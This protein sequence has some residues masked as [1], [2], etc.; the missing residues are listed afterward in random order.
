M[1]SPTWRSS[2]VLKLWVTI[3]A[4]VILVFAVLSVL[5]Q[6]FLDGYMWQQQTPQLEQ[7][8]SITSYFV[9]VHDTKAITELAAVHR[10]EILYGSVTSSKHSLVRAKYDE[11]NNAQKL[12]LKQGHSVIERTIDHGVDT[13]RIVRPLPSPIGQQ[14]V[15]VVSQSTHGIVQTLARMRNIISFAMVLGIVLTTVMAFVISNKVSRPLLEMN[16]IAEQM[17]SGN[18][19]GKIRVASNDEVGRLGTTFN[20]LA[21][22]LEHSLETMNMERKQLSS[23]L[24]SLTDGVV[25]SDLEGFITLANPPALRRLS[26]VWLIDSGQPETS[27][28]PQPLEVMLT[29]VVESNST[30]VREFLWQDR[31]VRITMTPLYEQNGQTLRGTVA[32]LRDVTEERRLDRLRKDFIANV[33]HEL[34]TPLSMMQG[35]A[36]ALLDEFGDNPAQ[37]RQLTEIIHDETLRMRRLVNDLLDLAQLES[38]HF[39]L[40][41]FRLD[42][43]ALVR[44]VAR[45]FEALASEQGLYFDTQVHSQPIY[46]NGDEDRLEQVFTNLLDNAIRHTKS[47][48][49]VWIDL[50]ANRNHARV[51]V[52]DTGS[53]IPEEDLPY[54]WERFYKADKARTRTSSGIGLGLAITRHIVN[55]H[56]GDIVVDSQVGVGTTFTVI[57]PVAK[58]Q[59]KDQTRGQGG[60]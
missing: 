8:A 15:I 53:G 23:I 29:A 12:T 2:I 42:L 1:K 38:G 21:S 58:E 37:R 11:L 13:L 47:T 18:F 41:V 27:R 14:R 36:E 19:G 49:R 39:Q 26:S 50:S 6:Q 45:K 4:M 30:L 46:C 57:L 33:S 28:L 52:S 16:A 7:L 44:R 17:A 25:A 24:A 35:Y 32:V 54:I 31:Q 43:V 40:H 10:V 51:R 5:L 60:S 22:R 55:K 3:V 20:L 48:G 9:K 59:E 56:R 34:R